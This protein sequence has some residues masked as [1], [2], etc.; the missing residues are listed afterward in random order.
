MQLVI[1]Y[2]NS[3]FIFDQ[4]SAELIQNVVTTRC[5]NRETDGILNVVITNFNVLL[6]LSLASI[7]F[8]KQDPF[9]KLSQFSNE[10][11]EIT[12]SR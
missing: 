3:L 8:K 2:R 9:Y 7:S 1:G 5:K 4:I 12:L 10:C 11:S 6:I